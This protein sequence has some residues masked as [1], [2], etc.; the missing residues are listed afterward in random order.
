MD[1][2]KDDAT[3]Q[4][5]EAVEEE[6]ITQTKY[7]ASSNFTNDNSFFSSNSYP[8][9]PN[10]LNSSQSPTNFNNRPSTKPQNQCIATNPL[11]PAYLKT[12]TDL[13]RESSNMTF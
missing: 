10:T 11:L 7:V 9:S 13:Y 3:A 12:V 2:G 8:Q 1:Q 6:E 4:T 5:F